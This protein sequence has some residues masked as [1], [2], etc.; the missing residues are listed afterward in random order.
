MILKIYTFISIC[1]YARLYLNEVVLQ[2]DPRVFMCVSG[3][4]TRSLRFV[5][6]LG[7]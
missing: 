7:P 5:A 3:P 2:G 6:V 1:S 4:F